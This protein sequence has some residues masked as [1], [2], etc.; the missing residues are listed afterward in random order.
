[1]GDH[2]YSVYVCP[3]YGSPACVCVS[4]QEPLWQH[5]TV[6]LCGVCVEEGQSLSE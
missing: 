2:K 6:S 3:S 5:P 1:M 4:R